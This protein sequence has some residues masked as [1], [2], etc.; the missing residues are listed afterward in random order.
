MVKQAW[1]QLGL[2]LGPTARLYSH[3]ESSV[4]FNYR[5]EHSD[6]ELPSSV[7]AAPAAELEC[8]RCHLNFH[9]QVPNLLSGYQES[10]TRRRPRGKERKRK[11][12]RQSS[13][14]TLKQRRGSQRG[15]MMI[16]FTRN[17]RNGVTAEREN[18]AT[19]NPPLGDIIPSTKDGVAVKTEES[20]PR[21]S[22]Y[23][24]IIQ[25]HQDLSL[26]VV[27]QM[28]SNHSELEIVV[29]TA[30]EHM[31]LGSKPRGA[32]ISGG[33]TGKALVLIAPAI[34]DTD[35]LRVLLPLLLFS[36]CTANIS[37]GVA[38]RIPLID[39]PSNA[40]T[41]FAANAESASLRK[42][43]QTL[44]I[45][46]G[47]SSTSGPE[48]SMRLVETK[49]RELVCTESRPVISPRSSQAS[50]NL[51][52]MP[53]FLDQESSH[54]GMFSELEAGEGVL[55]PDEWPFNQAPSLCAEDVS[56]GYNQEFMPPLV[57][58]NYTAE[59]ALHSGMA[60]LSHSILDAGRVFDMTD[61][62]VTAHAQQHAD[63]PG[64]FKEYNDRMLLKAQGSNDR[65]E[66]SYSSLGSQGSTSCRAHVQQTNFPEYF[67][68]YHDRLLF[69]R[70]A[71]GNIGEGYYP[72]PDSQVSVSHR[73]C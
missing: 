72:S 25:G 73:M 37:Q 49:L 63:L 45:S 7:L 10:G 62:P 31:L 65:S 53:P 51:D 64:Y 15:R 12:K 67:K 8:I 14:D 57:L 16:N 61:M 71:P 3:D 9:A 19:R 47:T 33:F 32:R 60:G 46:S 36:R 43:M 48:T 55:L 52:C 30:L 56:C 54:M 39:G 66:Y 11:R 38:V 69:K 50:K 24:F 22:D 29:R 27:T 28:V 18:M 70:E 4:A 17:G 59:R 21:D 20:P 2:Q 34:F 68:E 58:G 5:V 40:I 26:E 1:Q 41:Y 42:K 23:G 6:R 35:R 13:T 44:A